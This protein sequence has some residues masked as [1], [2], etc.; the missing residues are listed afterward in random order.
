LAVSR[1]RPEAGTE[2]AIRNFFGDWAAED[3][4]AA[5]AAA[6]GLTDF[7]ERLAAHEGLLAEGLAKDPKSAVEW[8]RGVEPKA[9][10]EVLLDQAL[11]DW[12]GVDAAGAGKYVAGLGTSDYRT[13]LA[14]ELARAW[15][16]KDGAGAMAWGAGLQDQEAREE[17]LT[18]AVHTVA[19]TDVRAAA[20]MTLKIK[21][22][23][24]RDDA[25]ELAVIAWWEREP[26][27]VAAWAERI[28]DVELRAQAQRVVAAQREAAGR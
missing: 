7:A 16:A 21:H 24:A 22:A 3:E 17:A 1:R 5:R 26:S 23:T 19:A 25:L 18:E 28:P 13:V 2:T 8:L 12:A 14:G 11:A 9:L 20:Q 10:A 6:A 15:A 27:A 4:T